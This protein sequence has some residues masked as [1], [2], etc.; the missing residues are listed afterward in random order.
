MSQFYL[1]IPIYIITENL[2]Y[3]NGYTGKWSIDDHDEYNLFSQRG[4]TLSVNPKS[5]I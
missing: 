2:R 3:D 1:R 4:E 5:S